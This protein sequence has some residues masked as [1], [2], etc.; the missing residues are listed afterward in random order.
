[1]SRFIELDSILSILF[2]LSS[3]LLKNAVVAFFN[4]AKCEAKLRTEAQ[5]NDLRR[6]F[7]IASMRR[8][9]LSNSSTAAKDIRRASSC[10]ES[11]GKFGGGSAGW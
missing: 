3:S 4:L 2:I 8:R 11:C 1:L 7:V 6:H 9:S 10:R 5:N